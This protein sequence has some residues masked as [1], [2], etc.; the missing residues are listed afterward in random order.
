MKLCPLLNQKKLSSFCD[1][2]KVFIHKI[3]LFDIFVFRL[4]KNNLNMAQTKDTSNKS[5]LLFV[6]LAKEATRKEN[7]FRLSR[8]SEKFFAS[9]R[10]VRDSLLRFLLMVVDSS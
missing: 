8:S 1:H 6:I 9:H 3:K 5:T 10:E 2:K 7:K 4:S